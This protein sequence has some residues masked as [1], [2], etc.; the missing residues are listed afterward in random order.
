MN[1]NRHRAGSF[2]SFETLE[3]RQLLSGG[4][5][6]L[7]V[8]L[9]K[10]KAGFDLLITGTKKADR[11]GITQDERGIVIRD[12]SASKLI[13]AKLH[14]IIVNGGEGND[15]IGVNSVIKIRAALN[16]GSGH[17]VIIGGGGADLIN[18]GAG[19][20]SLYGGGGNDVIVGAAGN[21]SLYGNAGNDSLV[22]NAGDD[23]LVTLGGG[24]YDTLEGDAGFDSFWTDSSSREIVTD[25][26]SAEEKYNGAWHQIEEFIPYFDKEGDF[27]EIPLE[28]DGDDL[29]D[30]ELDFDKDGNYNADDYEDYSDNPLFPSAGP[31]IDDINQGVLGDCYFLSTLAAGA[32]TNPAWIRQSV[33]DLGDRT[34]AVRFMTE[35]GGEAYVRVDSEL[36]VHEV[37]DSGGLGHLEPAYAGLASEDSIWVAVMEKAFAYY[38]DPSNTPDGGVDNT[39]YHNLNHGWMDEPMIAL[40]GVDV[41]AFDVTDTDNP[42]FKDGDDLLNWI[43][44]ER[45]DGRAVTMATRGQPSK[46]FVESHAYTVLDVV[47]DENGGRLLKLRNPWG[48]DGHSSRDGK[49]DGYIYVTAEEAFASASQVA[50]G[51]I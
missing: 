44:K 46:V 8:L 30:P 45:L 33:V 25:K 6:P 39:S 37:D 28:P 49:D 19:N 40:G 18:G 43:V 23:V 24:R 11:I 35:D 4:S 1:R 10:T 48:T 14:Q 7:D 41:E 22:G 5:F 26:L 9:Q 2:E 51:T 16:G 50:S 20:D 47:A 31:T 21:D 27:T 3:P 15:L 12:G 29:P 36:P 38:R 42:P 17:D 34:Y 32:E 13:R